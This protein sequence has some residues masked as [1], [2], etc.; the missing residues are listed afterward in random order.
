MANGVESVSSIIERG[1]VG[2]SGL[3]QAPADTALLQYGL[4]SAPMGSIACGIISVGGMPT[5]LPQMAVESPANRVE[6]IDEPDAF[7]AILTI[8]FAD[9]RGRAA[10]PDCR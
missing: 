2:H 3:S 7:G 10:V 5:S 8:V 4:Q 6:G 9:L 1:R